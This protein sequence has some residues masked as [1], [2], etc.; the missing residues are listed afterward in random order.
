MTEHRHEQ[1]GLEAHARRLF[2]ESVDAVD[3]PTRARLP[4]VVLRGLG[5]NWSGQPE[6]LFAGPQARFR[7]QLH[8]PNPLGPWRIA[9]V[10]F[11]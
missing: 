9:S 4:P 6:L 7:V 2:D 1:E 10:E 8:Q 3:G 11:E 5:H